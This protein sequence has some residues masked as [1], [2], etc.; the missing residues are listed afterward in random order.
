MCRIYPSYTIII[1]INILNLYK[2][3]IYNVIAYGFL[4]KIGVPVLKPPYG[5]LT[6]Y[7]SEYHPGILLGVSG[8][9]R[10]L[11]LLR[12]LLRLRRAAGGPRGSEAEEPLFRRSALAARLEAGGAKRGRQTSPKSGFNQS[13]NVGLNMG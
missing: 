2:L 4:T 7:H 13:R 10:L 6:T 3:Y 9:P 11:R 5:L 1:Y 8:C 12:L